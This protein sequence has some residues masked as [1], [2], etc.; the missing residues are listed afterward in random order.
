MGSQ[1]AARFLPVGAIGVL[2]AL[3][4]RSSR[5]QCPWLLRTRFKLG[6]EK[7]RRAISNRPRRSDLMRS[8]AE[9]SCERNMGSAP[10]WGASCTTKFCNSNPGRGRSLRLT[11]PTSTCRPSA[12]LIERTIRERSPCAPGRTRHRARTSST[13]AMRRLFLEGRNLNALPSTFAATACH[14]R[15][16]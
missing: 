4:R 8:V 16:V 13:P 9:T 15:N 3:S 12:M 7:S 1:G 14:R 6:S 5:F 2:A 11:Q 10:N